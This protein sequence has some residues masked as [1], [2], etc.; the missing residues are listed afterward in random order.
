MENTKNTNKNKYY[1]KYCCY[2]ASRSDAYQQHMQ[3]KKH[4]KN[5]E[6]TINVVGIKEQDGF[7]CVCGKTYIHQ[8]SLSK[9]KKKCDI[10]QG[11]P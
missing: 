3:T 5:M 6:K 1:C 4:Q 10:A 7:Q 2:Q 9:H 8:S 11:S